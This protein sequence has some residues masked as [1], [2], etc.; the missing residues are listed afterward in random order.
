MKVFVHCSDGR[1]FGV[2]TGVQS[3]MCQQDRRSLLLCGWISTKF[4]TAIGVADVIISNKFF[5]DRSRGVDSVGVKNCPLLLT[6]PVAVNT[7]LA[8]L[9]SPWQIS[10]FLDSRQQS[11]RQYWMIST[12]KKTITKKK[13]NNES[14]CRNW[15]ID[16]HIQLHTHK[17]TKAIHTWTVICCVIECKNSGWSNNFLITW[18]VT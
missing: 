11:N 18:A 2:S 14:L 4:G 17:Y 7:G 15:I 6:T 8:L 5:G 10:T 1:V 12:E 3:V 13:T 16:P 9:R